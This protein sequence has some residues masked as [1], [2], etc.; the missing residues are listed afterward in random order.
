MQKSKSLQL[1]SKEVAENG[2]VDKEVQ[3]ENSGEYEI[4]I[5]WF[6]EVIS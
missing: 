4:L 6:K 1:F 5:F 2:D 3:R